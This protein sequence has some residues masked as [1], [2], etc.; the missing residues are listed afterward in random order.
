M[1][2]RQQD[3]GIL[4]WLRQLASRVDRLEKG[5]KGVRINDTRLGDSVLT[6]NTYTG[7]VEMKNLKDGSMTP[8]SGIRDL[9]FS[10]SG[11][12]AAGD[13]PPA[14]VP[15]NSVVSEIVITRTDADGA[16]GY[17]NIAVVF[18]GITINTGIAAGVTT[19]A[20]PVHISVKRNDIIYC[21]VMC[22]ADAITNVSV[23]LRFGQ[24]TDL[25]DNTTVED[26]GCLP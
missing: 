17:T 21:E 1:S 23:S 22:A 18:P 11:A 20:R 24:P 15:D 2:S 7:Q 6:P 9:V 19:N 16:V 10:Y 26:Y 14:C 8:L 4:D 12:L 25:A 5:D 3:A 13:S